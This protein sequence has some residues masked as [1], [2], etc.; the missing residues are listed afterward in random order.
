[1]DGQIRYIET[2]G[3]RTI[4][5]MHGGRTICSIYRDPLH[6]RWTD[7]PVDGR[8]RYIETNLSQFSEDPRQRTGAVV[9]VLGKEKTVF[10]QRHVAVQ[11]R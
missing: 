7:D 1:M 11:D 5:C 6:A 9:P 8:I 4:R 2:H 3:G 10:R